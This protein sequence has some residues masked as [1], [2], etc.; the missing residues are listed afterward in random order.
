MSLP[1][2]RGWRGPVL[3]VCAAVMLL[4][5]ASNPV[6][7]VSPQAPAPV[8]PNFDLASRWTSA[9]VVEAGVRHQ[10]DAAL[11]AE[12]RSLLVQLPDARGP[13][14]LHGR[15]GEEGEGAA[16]RPRED[17][18]GADV[19]HA[20]ALRRA[21][22]AVLEHQV[23]EERHGVRVRRLRSRATPTSS[24]PRRRSRRLRRRR[25]AARTRA[26]RWTRPIR[27]SQQQGS[28]APGRARQRH[29]AAQPHAAL[30][31]RHGHREGDARRGLRG[32]AGTPALGDALAR[33]PDRALRPQPQPL[34]DG[35]G[36]LRQGAE[37]GRPT[38]R[39]S[40]RSSPPTARR[41]TATRA[42]SAAGRTSN[43]SNSSRT[44]RSS[45][46][47]S[48]N[49][50]RTRAPRRTRTRACPRSTS[51]GRPTRSSSRWSAATSARS[52]TSG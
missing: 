45:R 15:S 2:A 19:D 49:S 32:A 31:V 27:S 50:S 39:S 47:T 12:R 38:R 5:P 11:A 20:P 43:S 9:K 16:L 42:R 10:R 23:R 14:V 17:G 33:R 51:S 7:Q 41:T 24:P 52:R 8:A 18:R 48:S 25:A 26:R 30:R 35:R 36:Q 37:D 44:S 13:P 46:T 6:A 29:A 21:A 34:H 22:P 28:A 4:S 1:F 3:V 40:R